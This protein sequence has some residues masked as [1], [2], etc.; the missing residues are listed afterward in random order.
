MQIWQSK[1]FVLVLLSIVIFLSISVTRELLRRFEI[2]YEIHKLEGDVT[3]LQKRNSDLQDVIA[4]LNSSSLQDKEAR[5]KLG[6]QA[7]GEHVVLFPDRDASHAVTLPDSDT[8]RY[9]PI[10]EYKSNPE[11][12]FSYFWDKLQKAYT[13]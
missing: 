8:I 12:W 2:T 6:L 5:V 7:P 9:I 3:R 10:R 13:L 11:K 1:T 4:L